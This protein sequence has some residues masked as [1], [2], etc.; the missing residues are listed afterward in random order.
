[1]KDKLLPG[2]VVLCLLVMSWLIYDLKSEVERLR[3]AVGNRN[4]SANT[5]NALNVP[6]LTIQ[7]NQV[8]AAA[9]LHYLELLAE[10]MARKNGLPVEQAREAFKKRAGGVPPGW[11]WN[12]AWEG[13]APVETPPAK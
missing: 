5:V 4:D 12:A 6:L 3:F 11:N 9:G 2:L 1:V 7:Q 10:G 13:T 8:S